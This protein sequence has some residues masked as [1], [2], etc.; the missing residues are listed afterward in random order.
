MIQ[1]NDKETAEKST[2]KVENANPI[3]PKSLLHNKMIFKD[4]V[5]ILPQTSFR[6]LSHRIIPDSTSNGYNSTC[7]QGTS[8]RNIKICLVTLS[9]SKN[10]N[11][12]IK[13]C[14]AVNVLMK[15]IHFIEEDTNKVKIAPCKINKSNIDVMK[16]IKGGKYADKEFGKY[17]YTVRKGQ[18]REGGQYVR[19]Q[20]SVA[21]D[22]TW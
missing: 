8:N 16:Y 10:D 4:A 6:I 18:Y 1:Q 14:K 21:H 9:T 7:K 2:P 12:A 22:V 5:L 17:V 3:Y 15:L 20:L 19:I 11:N 13:L